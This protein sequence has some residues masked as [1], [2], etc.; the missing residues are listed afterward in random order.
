MFHLQDKQKDV[1]YV[2]QR[3]VRAT[4]QPQTPKNMQHDEKAQN[5]DREHGPIV[6]ITVD[7]KPY[8]I[9]R[10]RQTVAEI[11][12]VAGVPLAFDLEQLID[13]RL[14]PLADDASVTIKGGEVFLSHPKDGGAS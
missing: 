14:T 2:Q 6:T 12:Q 10:G 9:H 1:S 5:E 13:G 3:C 4:A 8:K 7:T 11:K